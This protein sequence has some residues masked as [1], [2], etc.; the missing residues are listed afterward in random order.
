VTWLLAFGIFCCWNQQQK[1]PQSPAAATATSRY[2]LDRQQHFPSR[3]NTERPPGSCAA[4]RRAP[5]A[6]SLPFG[7]CCLLLFVVR[8]AG[9]CESRVVAVRVSRPGPQHPPPRPPNPHRPCEMGTRYSLALCPLPV[10]Q[11]RGDFAACH[12]SLCPAAL[13]WLFPSLFLSLS[14]A[15]FLCLPCYPHHYSALRRPW[16]SLRTATVLSVSCWSV[17]CCFVEQK[18]RE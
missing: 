7:P 17:S 11:C 14:P 3:Q 2:P 10:L 8:V 6:F 1:K 5:C 16:R 18:L 13:T 15:L 9:S 4:Q 12:L